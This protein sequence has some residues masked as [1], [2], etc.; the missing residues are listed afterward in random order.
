MTIEEAVLEIEQQKK[1]VVDVYITDRLSCIIEDC[2]DFKK[3]F[4]ED[5][6]IGKELSDFIANHD[7]AHATLDRTWVRA[8]NLSIMKLFRYEQCKVYCHNHAQ[9][10]KKE[11]DGETISKWIDVGSA[12]LTLI[13]SS[14]A[15]IL[16]AV[17]GIGANSEGEFDFDKVGFAI[18]LGI[19]LLSIVI[20]LFAKVINYRR[21]KKLAN[22]PYSLE[23]LL[24][25]R[26]EQ[27][28]RMLLLN[29]IAKSQRDYQVALGSDVSRSLH[30]NIWKT[31]NKG[32]K[33][34]INQNVGTVING[35][36]TLEMVSKWYDSWPG[37]GKE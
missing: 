3:C 6:E 18:V 1:R 5:Y 16:F 25:V 11:I 27:K 10:L 36:A 12:F 35:Q 15:M 13:F 24:A 9:E 4:G 32:N 28:P 7:S 31:N 26:Y 17:C 23:E 29:P 20:W 33:G 21:R 34:Q 37:R 30:I 22:L 8:L 14:L 19:A 2:N